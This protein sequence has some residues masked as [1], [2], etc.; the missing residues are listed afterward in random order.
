[1][2]Q[3]MGNDADSIKRFLTIL[4]LTAEEITCF[5][6]LSQK[7][8]LTALELSRATGISRTQVYRIIEEMKKMGFVEDIIDEHRHLIKAVRVEELAPLIRRK[9]N[10]AHEVKTL[11]PAAVRLVDARIGAGEADTKVLF[12]RGREGLRQ[13]VWHTLRARKVI[14][15]YTYRRL[16]EYLGYEFMEDWND[17]LIA[18]KLYMRDI[19]SDEYVKSRKS[20][21]PRVS[22]PKTSYSSRYIPEKI[23]NVNL[24]M[25][26]YN[27]VVAQYNWH[28]GDVFGVEIYNAKTAAF[29]RQM[30]EI[31]W[32]LGKTK[33]LPRQLIK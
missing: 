15:G 18:K 19:Y 8:P 27:D 17:A 10:E 3:I 24:Q 2:G 12:Y 1:M 20:T 14:V 13:M 4:G 26:I 9:E 28:E 6:T 23:L 7:G 31:I 29:H 30:F 5:L 16:E 25:D 32:K 11:F 33:P 21:P 22:Y